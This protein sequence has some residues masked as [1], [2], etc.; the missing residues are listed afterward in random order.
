M[1]GAVLTS[2]EKQSLH[3]RIWS[4]KTR[5]KGVEGEIEAQNYYM[6]CSRSHCKS[7]KNQE[8]STGL[9][10]SRSVSY[11][12]NHA[13]FLKDLL[14]VYTTDGRGVIP[15]QVDIPARPA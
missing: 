11:P 5:Q 7:V 3:H 6:T 4:K 1:L 10:T 2:S 8:S 12:L 9:Q 13:A 14:Y 15:A